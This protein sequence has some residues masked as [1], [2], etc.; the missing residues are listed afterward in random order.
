MQKTGFIHLS[1]PHILTSYDKGYFRNLSKDGES[2]TDNLEVAL[3][4]IAGRFGGAEF[5]LI[6]GDLTHEGGAEDYG[7]LRRI[8]EE[9]VKCPV[10]TTLGNHDDPSSFRRGYLGETRGDEACYYAQGVNGLRIIALDTMVSGCESGK[11][12]G[13]QLAWLK[14][15]LQNPS[16]RGSIL[17]LHHPPAREIREGLFQRGLEN[18]EDLLSCIQGGDIRAIFS[19]HTHRSGAMTF[20]GIPHYTA[21]STAFGVSF[22]DSYLHITSQRSFNYGIIHDH[23]IYIETYP[24]TDAGKIIFSIPL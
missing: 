1:D 10:F 13:E 15:L 11:L 16:P 4:H 20:G 2:P 19:G 8:L 24:L 17:L 3:A 7:L 18:P 5:M 14:A 6:T 23:E 22:D 9:N 12:G 21:G